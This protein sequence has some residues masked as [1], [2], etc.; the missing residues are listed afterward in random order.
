MNRLDLVI[1]RVYYDNI[2]IIEVERVLGLRVNDFSAMYEK[3]LTNSTE[4]KIGGS[5]VV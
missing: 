2:T 3:I 5:T 1:Y 4:R